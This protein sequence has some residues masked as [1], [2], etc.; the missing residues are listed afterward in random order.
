MEI[1]LESFSI[2]LKDN[3][4]TTGS[5]IR[6]VFHPNENIEKSLNEEQH[7]MPRLYTTIFI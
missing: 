5:E 7:L 6:R 2:K 3:R 1:D 4:F